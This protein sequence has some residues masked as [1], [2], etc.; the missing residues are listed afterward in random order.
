MRF[1]CHTI[2]FG[3]RLGRNLDRILEVISEAGFEGVEVFQAPRE[4]GDPNAFLSKLRDRDLVLLGLA[5]G[6]LEDR[7]EFLRQA[8]FLPGEPKPYLYLD[9]WSPLAAALARDGYRL[10]VH[11]HYL[12]RIEDDD[13]V[14]RLLKEHSNLLYL[15][16]TAHS[17][18][19]GMEMHN[20][21]RTY[22]HRLAAVHI[23]DWR[24]SFGRSSPLYARGFTSLG[25]GRVKESIVRTL[26]TLKNVLKY[27]GWVVFELDYAEG[28][29]EQ[30][31]FD[32]ACWLRDLGYL[33][34]N[35]TRAEARSLPESE[36]REEDERFLCKL[37]LRLTRIS[38]HQISTAYE[39]LASILRQ[40][41]KVERVVLW[42][43][44]ETEQWMHV[45][46][47]DPLQEVPK[48]IKLASDLDL[49]RP[50]MVDP[51]CLRVPVTSSWNPNQLRF[52]I[53]FVGA[54]LP[55]MGDE[56]W[57]CVQRALARFGDTLLD[58]IGMIA[59]TEV[60]EASSQATSLDEFAVSLTDYVEKTIGCETAVLFLVDESRT[61][62][63]A[64]PEQNNKKIIWNDP[65]RQFYEKGD[66][67]FTTAVWQEIRRPVAVHRFETTPFRHSPLSRLAVR[68]DRDPSV[69]IMPI[70][71]GNREIVGLM[72][73]AL[74]KNHR[75]EPILFSDEDVAL[76]DQ[77]LL[78]A[79]PHLVRLQENE[80]RHW[81]ML[82]VTHEFKR[83]VNSLRTL[84][85][86]LRYEF[87]ER[88]REG[89]RPLS[90]DYLGDAESWTD[91]LRALMQRSEYFTKNPKKLAIRPERILLS[92]DVIAPVVRQL[93]MEL[94]EE[95]LE[96]DITFPTIRD[97]PAIWV[98]R[99]M[100]QQVF[101]N[102]LDN[103]IKYRKPDAKG[104]K[105]AVL[106]FDNHSSFEVQVI[107]CGIGIPENMQDE[108]FRLGTRSVNAH[109]FKI[110]GT[111]IGLWLVK[112]L[113]EKHGCTIQLKQRAEPTVFSITIP[114]SLTREPRR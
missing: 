62:L 58:D 26:D 34:P 63:Y 83:P 39:Q 16:D 66:D 45:L 102:L 54:Q 10:A 106:G 15:P 6:S 67:Q 36:Q 108:I 92:R 90:H 28:L 64:C 70:I 114:P 27:Q 79:L 91:L 5:G 89:I 100:F 86:N 56:A 41:F 77:I 96:E 110:A 88:E 112:S 72:K 93:R 17:Y 51:Q 1:G 109:H 24:S 2:I 23:K 25:K 71:D 101:F 29:R 40:T 82:K 11:P 46:G 50:Q 21:L 60:G 20:L 48:P 107:D 55:E 37:L 113:L 32:A 8:N 103:A 75:E 84:T 65:D 30:A 13:H 76:L 47:I 99:N 87:R 33:A 111:G 105:I 18:I 12:K 44:T 98:D 22:F 7:A 85:K 53:D 52:M 43:C 95:D 49:C 74:R 94:R 9:S 73:C 97:V 69:L 78:A 80:R 61:R 38:S 104:V 68:A 14:R 81:Q 59:V 4:L 42:S 19:V 35:E 57:D 31:V 3:P